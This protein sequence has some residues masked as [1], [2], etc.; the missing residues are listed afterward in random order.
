M[1]DAFS[2]L[3]FVDDYK[4]RRRVNAEVNPARLYLHNMTERLLLAYKYTLELL[5]TVVI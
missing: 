5:E 4:I 2:Q 3:S 1:K